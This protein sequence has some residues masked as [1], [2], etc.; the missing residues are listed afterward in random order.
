MDTPHRVKQRFLA[1]VEI[2]VDDGDLT[3]TRRD[4]HNWLV[5]NLAEEGGGM[6]H[7]NV[8]QVASLPARPEQ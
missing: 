1:V 3:M 4:I 7:I 2:T 6:I 5:R 8:N